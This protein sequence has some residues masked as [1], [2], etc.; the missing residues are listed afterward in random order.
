MITLSQKTIER[1]RAMRA[2]PESDAFL[3][4]PSNHWILSVPVLDGHGRKTMISFSFP[5]ATP[6]ARC[7]SA[8]DTILLAIESNKV[9]TMGEAKKLQYKLLSHVQ[10]LNNAKPAAR[11][12]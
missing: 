10:L 6:L 2:H 4:R 12:H 7:K 9:N 8:R 3:S 11:G 1:V 5:V